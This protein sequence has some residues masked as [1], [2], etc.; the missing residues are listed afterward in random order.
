[1][2]QLCEITNRHLVLEAERYVPVT[3]GNPWVKWLCK[4]PYLELH[5][6]TSNRQSAWLKAISKSTKSRPQLSTDYYME[7]TTVTHFS[8]Q[9][10]TLQQWTRISSPRMTNL[11][12]FSDI[13][14]RIRIRSQLFLTCIDSLVKT[15]FSIRPKIGLIVRIPSR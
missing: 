10:T 12:P 7:F 4:L 15:R 3:V 8:P 5:K 9:N 11:V 6:M 14:S 1:M 13:K 2:N